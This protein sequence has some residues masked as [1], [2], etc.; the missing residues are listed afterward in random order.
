[1]NHQTR[2]PV[3]PITTAHLFAGLS[4]ELVALLRDLPPSA[5]DA[6]TVCGPWTVRDVVAHLL[7]TDLRQLSIHRDG[8]PLLKPS[9]PIETHADLIAFLDEINSQWIFAARRLSAPVLIDLLAHVEGQVAAYYNS[10]DMDAL[11]PFGVGWAGEKRSYTWFHVAREY[12]EKWHHQQH[13]RDAVERPG[14]LDAV[15]GA[16]A[17][18]TFVRA[19]PYTYRA[20]TA[21]QNTAVSIH[22][23]GP[24]G[25]AW[26]LVYTDGSWGLYVEGKDR[27]DEGRVAAVDAQRSS[28][29]FVRVTLDQDTAWRFFTKGIAPNAARARSQV[30]GDPSLAA[31]FFAAVSILA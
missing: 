27:V 29:R 18:D 7:D 16:P 8:A 9:R 3:G 21:A 28:L 13:I 1:M 17:L 12:T 25:G 31:P 22:I 26:T 5:W 20:V 30:A 24:A 6:P 14:L 23:T 19:L 11:A 4:T 10:L 15:Y 2:T